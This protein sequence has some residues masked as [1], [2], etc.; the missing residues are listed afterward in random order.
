MSELS[1]RSFVGLAAGMPAFAWLA[2]PQGAAGNAPGADRAGVAAADSSR[3]V[4]LCT[5]TACR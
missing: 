1:R 3:H 2:E 4:V 5:A